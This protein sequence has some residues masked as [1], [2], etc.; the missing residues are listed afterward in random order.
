MREKALDADSEDVDGKA[1]VVRQSEL[2]LDTTVD[3]KSRDVQP[4]GTESK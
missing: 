4:T 3:G 2:S 1:N